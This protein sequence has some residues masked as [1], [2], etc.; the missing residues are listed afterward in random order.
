MEKSY[1]VIFFSI[2]LIIVGIVSIV[3]GILMLTGYQEY[4]ATGEIASFGADFYTYV[5]RN[6]ARSASNTYYIFKTLSKGFGYCLL[7]AG[8]SLMIFGCLKLASKPQTT[9]INNC[10]TNSVVQ[11]TRKKDN[12][13]EL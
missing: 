6:A 9:V 12:L 5:N 2:L 3:F 1:A 4:G 10:E 13:P 8:A 7:I 11:E